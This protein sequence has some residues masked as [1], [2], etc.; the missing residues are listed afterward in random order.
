MHCP[1][2]I[3]SSVF[4]MLTLLACQSPPTPP[5]ESPTTMPGDTLTL[6]KGL[7]DRLSIPETSLNSGGYA[8]TCTAEPGGDVVCRSMKA[9]DALPEALTRDVVKEI[10]LKTL[11]YSPNRTV[12][13]VFREDLSTGKLTTATLERE[14]MAPMTIVVK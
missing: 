11:T 6:S 7:V 2:L 13:L 3:A 5:T 1:T 8:L 12:T 9:G 10:G 4:L 14:W